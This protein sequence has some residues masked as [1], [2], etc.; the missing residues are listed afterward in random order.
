MTIH[1]KVIKLYPAHVLGTSEPYLFGVTDT[2]LGPVLII[3]RAGFLLALGFT[4]SLLEFHTKN[5]PTAPWVQDADLA[6]QVWQALEEQKEVKAVLLGT[7]FQQLVWKAL[8]DL[9]LGEVVT[10]R[11]IAHKIGRPKAVRAV[12]NAIGANPIAK[13]IPCQVRV[14]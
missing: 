3:T 6:Q 12:A 7:E 14:Y 11:D 9:K 4:E 10:Y 2:V 5:W 1:H 13:I 8:L